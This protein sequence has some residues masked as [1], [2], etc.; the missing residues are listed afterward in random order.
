LALRNGFLRLEK[1]AQFFTITLAPP[2][3]ADTVNFADFERGQ[4]DVF[5]Y[6][7]EHLPFK[8]TI[9]KMRPPRDRFYE[10]P[11]RSKKRFSGKFISSTYVIVVKHPQTLGQYLSDKDGQNVQ[12]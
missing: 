4:Q 9:R 8:T 2:R 10:T 6:H 1:S 5:L 7:E 3:D 12:I 11:R